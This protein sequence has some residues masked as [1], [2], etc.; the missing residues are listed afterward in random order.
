MISTLNSDPHPCPWSDVIAF[1][2]L[3]VASCGQLTAIY[4]SFVG[5]WYILPM[6]CSGHLMTGSL[7]NGHSVLLITAMIHLI[8]TAKYILK[9]GVVTW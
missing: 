5:N 8:T 3:F 2:V 4:N 1:W 9:L 6:D 7:L